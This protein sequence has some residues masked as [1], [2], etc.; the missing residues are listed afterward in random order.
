MVSVFNPV[1]HLSMNIRC[2]TT[3]AFLF[4]TLVKFTLLSKEANYVVGRG[5]FTGQDPVIKSNEV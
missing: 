3:Q 5:N 2:R 1:F 4:N